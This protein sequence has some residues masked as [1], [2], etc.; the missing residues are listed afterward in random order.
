M[1]HNVTEL[2]EQLRAT[3]LA[4]GLSQRELGER[5]GLP[6]SNIARFES[7]GTDP[8]LSKMLELARALDLELKLV[9]RRALP[10]IAATLRAHELEIATNDATSRALYS[11]RQIKDAF[12]D[13]DQTPLTIA[14]NLR[15]MLSELESLHFDQGQLRA[16]RNALKLLE[17]SMDQWR[18]TGSPPKQWSRQVRDASARLSE[19]RKQIAQSAD[20]EQSHLKPAYS[21][22]D[23]DDD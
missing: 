1:N 2:I 13:I 11:I 19:L 23:I 9:P 17:R 7:G 12:V 15:N 6:Q 18:Q 4:Q 22:E 5:I 21:L 16:L 14:D 3:R 20:G 8:S 10:A